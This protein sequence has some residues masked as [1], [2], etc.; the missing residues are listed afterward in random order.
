MV[1]LNSSPLYE[2]P[3]TAALSQLSGDRNQHDDDDIGY[4]NKYGDRN[5]GDDDDCKNYDD[6]ATVVVI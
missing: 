6:S 3:T 1:I 5:D 4:S 2:A